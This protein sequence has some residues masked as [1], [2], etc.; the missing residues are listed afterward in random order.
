M[1]ANGK[2]PQKKI[3][4]TAEI[5][6][7]LGY[8]TRRARRWLKRNGA[9]CQIDQTEGGRP[10]YGTTRNLLQEALMEDRYEVWDSISLDLMDADS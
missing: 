6:E 5:A 9:L 3:F 1:A 4:T 10:L 2:K 7:M 8:S